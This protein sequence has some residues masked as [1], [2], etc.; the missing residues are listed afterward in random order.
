MWSLGSVLWVFSKNGGC[1]VDQTILQKGGTV[2]SG[3]DVPGRRAAAV[4]NQAMGWWLQM[5]SCQ[6]CYLPRT[7]SAEVR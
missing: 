4:H 5:V 2:F 3:D 1:L 6:K 7:L